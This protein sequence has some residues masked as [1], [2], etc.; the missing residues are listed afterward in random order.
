MNKNNFSRPS[1]AVA[2]DAWKKHLAAA[3]LPDEVVWVFAENLCIESQA[4]D[5]RVGFQTKFTPPDEDALE[6]AYDIFSGSAACIVFYRLGTAGN[7][8]VC[9]LL[10]DPWLDKRGAKEGFILQPDWNIVFRAG[11]AE[12]IEEITDLARWVRRVKRGRGLQDYDFALSLA[13]I[14]EIKLHGRPLMPYERMA[15]K[16]MDNLRRK[17]GAD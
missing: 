7:K 9:I 8:S 1:L 6:I 2:L 17:V 14:D 11:E 15:E 3:H 12:A 5:L 16:M 10:C 4:D 13:T